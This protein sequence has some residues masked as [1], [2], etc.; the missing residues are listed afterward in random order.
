LFK[1]LLLSAD[2]DIEQKKIL[3]DRPGELNLAW[4]RRRLRSSC[5]WITAALLDQEE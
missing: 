1:L 4:E 2:S 5:K 3:P